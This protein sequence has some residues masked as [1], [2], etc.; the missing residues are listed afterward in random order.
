[1]SFAQSFLPAVFLCLFAH[2]AQALP[3]SAVRPIDRDSTLLRLAQEAVPHVKRLERD[4]DTF[5][6]NPAS[7][8]TNHRYASPDGSRA[9]ARLS[10]GVQ[11]SVWNPNM[12]PRLAARPQMSDWFG[13][14]SYVATDPIASRQWGSPQTQDDMLGYPG[15]RADHPWWMTVITLKKGSWFL[16]I[17]LP[18]GIHTAVPNTLSAEL[19]QALDA[20]FGCKATNVFEIFQLINEDDKR[21]I[22]VRRDLLDRF[23]ISAV[24]FSFF[25]SEALKQKPMCRGLRRAAFFLT[26]KAPFAAPQLR[27]FNSAPP[28]RDSST[29]ERLNIQQTWLYAG[30]RDG[31]QMGDQHYSILWP[32]LLG[33]SVEQDEFEE[34]LK[35]RIFGCGSHE[36]DERS[37]TDRPTELN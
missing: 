14:G 37:L 7:D 33:Q 22:S 31:F 25:S 18:G 15:N 26:Q 36:E 23:R 35:N 13:T 9:A 20:Q 6:Y 5:Q 21:C 4:V 19:Q 34:Y 28:E 16:D 29:E 10:A 17:T 1:M 24:L 27:V 12:V 8:P 32:S 30:Y 11:A 3:R 2:S